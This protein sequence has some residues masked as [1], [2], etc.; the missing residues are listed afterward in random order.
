MNKNKETKKNKKKQKNDKPFSGWAGAE[1][2]P[3]SFSTL[4]ASDGPWQCE[5]APGMNG[6]AVMIERLVKT[7]RR[8]NFLFNGHFFNVVLI[9]ASFIRNVSRFKTF[10]SSSVCD[11]LA[12]DIVLI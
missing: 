3:R 8:Y 1:L 7:E 6:V 2:H 12:F 9:Y 4:G 10:L 5:C 11:S